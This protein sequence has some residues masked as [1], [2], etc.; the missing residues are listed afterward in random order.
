M[1]KNSRI[2]VAGHT[3]L[4]GSA[5]VRKLNGLGY[6]NIITKSHNELDLTRQ[7]K[8]ELFFE[9]EKPEYVFLAA[10]KVGGIGDS[11]RNPAPF[12]YENSMI[13]NNVI[14]NAHKA[15][16]KKLLFMGSSCIYPKLCKQPVIEEYLMSGY[17][18]STNEAYSIAKIAGLKMSQFYKTQYGD[19]F[20]ACMPC[21]L[22]GPNDNFNLET[23][24]V[25][26][27][28]IR[29]FVEAKKHSYPRVEIWGKGE[30]CREFL[31]ADDMADACVFLMNEYNG[32]Q[33]VNIGTGKEIPIKLLV[34]MIRSKVGYEGKIVFDSSRPDGTLRKCLDVSKLINLGWKY[35]I[36]LEDGLDSTINWYMTSIKKK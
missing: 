14:H 17:L 2:Y 11:S 8:V 26:P 15:G 3:G 27:A 1:E 35:S 34:E 23:S 12:F 32:Q 20:I 19:N 31:H 6:S 7:A 36:E 25:I 10:A 21:N 16:V 9:R 5:I 24:H 33:H 29:K 18:E 28:L 13:E 22:Y 4:V 30:A